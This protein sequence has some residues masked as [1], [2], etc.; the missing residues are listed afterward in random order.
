M[1]RRRS[2][3]DHATPSGLQLGDCWKADGE[4]RAD[5]QL[6]GDRD[7]PAVSF[8]DPITDR[9]PKASASRVGVTRRIY[10]VKPLKNPA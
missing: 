1:Q 6:A 9:E 7:L 4:S 2:L 5:I 8:N 10:S 3:K